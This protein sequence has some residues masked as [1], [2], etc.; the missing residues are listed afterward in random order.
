MLPTFY[1]AGS[2]EDLGYTLGVILSDGHLDTVRGYI[3]MTVKDKEF[4]E[5]FAEVLNRLGI[6]AR[7]RKRNKT[8]YYDVNVGAKAAVEL[9]ATLDLDWIAEQPEELKLGV[10]RGLWD[11][12]GCITFNK[13]RENWCPLNT[14]AVKDENLV[15]F[16]GSLV[17]Q[18]CGFNVSTWGPDTKGLFRIRFGGRERNLVFYNVVQPTIQRKVERFESLRGEPSAV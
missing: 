16:Y 15:D 10:L 4:A 9:L 3:M 7:V 8:P 11:G 18:L 13:Q 5:K 1:P 17:E 14:F 6:N 2:R 12:D